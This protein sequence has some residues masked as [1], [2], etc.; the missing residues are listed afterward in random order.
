MWTA[1]PED[2][3]LQLVPG[4]AYAVVASVKASHT[5]ADLRAFAAKRGLTVT[6]YAEQ[7]AR[8]GLGPDPRSPDYKYVAA[9]ATATAPGSIPWSV[10]WPLSMVDSSSLVSAWS[11]PAGVSSPAPALTSPS[12]PAAPA[13]PPIWP[14]AAFLALAG[15]WGAWKIRGRRR[16]APWP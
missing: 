2:Q 10:P 16:R 3:A 7:G 5:A 1:L 13:M 8:A 9:I 6:D 15:A 4:Q 11:E 14:V 12:S